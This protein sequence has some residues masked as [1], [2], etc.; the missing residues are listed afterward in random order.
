MTKGFSRQN[1]LTMKLILVFCC[2]K[3]SFAALRGKNST[4]KSH[5]ASTC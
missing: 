2:R 3:W 5:L 1:E 4:L